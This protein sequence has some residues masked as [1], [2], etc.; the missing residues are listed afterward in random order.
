MLFRT[1]V[2]LYSILPG[3]GGE[4]WARGG[5]EVQFGHAYKYLQ[6]IIGGE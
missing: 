3:G 5:V 1:Y 4:G 6:L 2:L